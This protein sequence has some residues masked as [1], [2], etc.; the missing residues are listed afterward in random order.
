MGARSRSSRGGGSRPDGQHFLRSRLIAAELVRGA[1]VGPADHVLEIGAGTGRL[2][3]PLAEYAGRVSAVE[4]DPQLV[5]RLRRTF[6][7]QP[8]VQVVHGDTMRTPLPA[9]RWRAFGNIPFSLTTPI[10]RRLLDDPTVELERADLLVQF[11]AARKRTAVDRST[12]SSL[13]WL[14]WWELALVRRIPRHG[15]EPPPSIDA[16]MLT[17]TRR[18]TEL[19]DRT[20]RFAYLALVR[21]A[22]NH[23]SWPVRR[24]LRGTMPPMAWK[25]L[26]RE[27][28]L[29][30]DA[31]PPDL[32]IWDWISVF[33]SAGPHE[34]PG[35]PTSRPR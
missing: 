14:P 18:R 12:L 17:I 4:L 25:R 23:G 32:D 35:S 7:G 20:E 31:R 11:E 29:H 33:R 30:V 21:R 22:F 34:P 26:A 16:G 8:H 27:R 13:G 15:F 10:L 1:D 5:E 2:T 3:R 19:L 6:E 28:G 24:S 9:G